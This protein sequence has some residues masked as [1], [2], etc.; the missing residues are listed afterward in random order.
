M[1]AL[2]QGDVFLKLETL[3]PTFSF[4]IRGALN[5]VLAISEQ[6]DRPSALVTASAGNH[7]QALAY[8]ARSAGLPLTVYV[9]SKAP[10]NKQ[11]AIQRMGAALI[12]C[13]DYDEAESRAKQHGAS[14]SAVFISPYSHPDVIA[15]A[16]TIALEMLEQEPELDTILV[17]VGG[18]GLVSGVA[19]AGSG[20]RAEVVG[21]EVQASCPFR[22]SLAAG[23]IVQIDV[24]PTIADGLSGN[25]DP[26]TI[27]FDIVRRLGTRMTLVDDTLLRAAIAGVL[28]EERLVVEAAGAA[29]VAAVLADAGR[30]R[31]HRTAV[32]LSGANI[33]RDVLASVI[34][35]PTR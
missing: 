35:S 32:V 1:S 7:G 18:G 4:K 10:R 11:E 14:G 8:A 22:E 12:A 28:V 13:A 20:S 30:M 25:L 2:T 5:A 17:P 29:G 6:A 21:V 9:P 16:G 31:G 26:E 3:Q 15:G 27:T 24:G 33:D 19:V 23:R 34:S